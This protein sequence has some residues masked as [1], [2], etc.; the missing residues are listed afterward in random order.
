MDG[1]RDLGSCV[2]VPPRWQ[3]QNKKERQNDYAAS[4]AWYS[5]G[6]Y[7]SWRDFLRWR[8]FGGRSAGLSDRTINLPHDP[9]CPLDRRRNHCVRPPDCLGDFRIDPRQSSDVEPRECQ[10]RSRSRASDPRPFRQSIMF[11]FISLYTRCTRRCTEIADW[12]LF[13]RLTALYPIV[14]Y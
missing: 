1:R 14:S 6:R 7:L 13:T 3:A 4:S 11:A 10:R 2:E 9:L 12:G 5:G 8:S